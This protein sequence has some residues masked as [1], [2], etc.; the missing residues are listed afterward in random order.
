MNQPRHNQTGI[1]SKKVE[2]IRGFM[3]KSTRLSTRQIKF[4]LRSNN[5]HQIEMWK[6]SD[7]I[8]AK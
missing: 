4:S 5:H 6:F 8:S 1:P 7:K 2:N 3:D